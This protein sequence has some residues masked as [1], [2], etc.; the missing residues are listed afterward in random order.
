MENPETK[1]F[2]GRVLLSL[3]EAVGKTGWHIPG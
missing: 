3:P 2:A 1:I